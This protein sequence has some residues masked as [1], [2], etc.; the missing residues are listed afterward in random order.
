MD[1]FRI[2]FNFGWNKLVEDMNHIKGK[3]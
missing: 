1:M 3:H 2:M